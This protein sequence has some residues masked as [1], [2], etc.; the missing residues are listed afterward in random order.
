ANRLSYF[1]DF[2]GPSLLVDTACSA[3]LVALHTAVRALRAGECGL[4][5]ACGVNV[6]CNPRISASYARAGMLAPD[7]RCKVFDDAADGYVRAEGAVV[8]LL[9]PLAQALADGNRIH[10]VVRGTA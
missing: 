7:G 6:I 9:K 8:M 1:Y 2:N 10:A 4:A 3:S 5:L